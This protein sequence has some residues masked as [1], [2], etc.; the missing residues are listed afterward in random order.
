MLE[1]RLVLCWMLGWYWYVR[2][3]GTML[4]VQLLLSGCSVGDILNVT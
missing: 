4:D 3:D 2:Q 1:G